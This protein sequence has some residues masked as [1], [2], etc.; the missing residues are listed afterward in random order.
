VC[1][2]CYTLDLSNVKRDWRT[3]MRPRHLPPGTPMNAGMQLVRNRIGCTEAGVCKCTRSQTMD[4]CVSSLLR[5][6]TA[7]SMKLRER[8]QCLDFA[9]E[10]GVLV[11]PPSG[12]RTAKHAHHYYS[13]PKFS[14]WHL[15][16][17]NL[18]GLS[19]NFV[20]LGASIR[21]PIN[22]SSTRYNNS[23]AT[24]PQSPRWR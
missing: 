9:G 14:Y 16:D 18:L 24:K 3:I 15:R 17:S 23:P 8:V 4:A 5:R 1:L 12:K 13:L 20:K 2:D 21:W 10:G 19:T 7:K 11:G 22:H 6:Q